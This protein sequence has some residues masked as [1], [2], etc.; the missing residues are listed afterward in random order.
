[1]SK[2]HD[3]LDF[4]D[5][6]LDAIE[7]IEH[8][9]SGMNFKTFSK[10]EKT[11]YAVIRAIEIIGEAARHIPVEIRQKYSEIPWKEISGMRD[12]LIHEYFGVDLKTLWQTIKEDIPATKPLIQKMIKSSQQ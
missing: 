7:K 12:I 8:F 5:D 4:L 11:I 9:V 3:F 10:D 2:R 1:M 6:I